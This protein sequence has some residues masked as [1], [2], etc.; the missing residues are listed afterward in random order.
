MS[1]AMP[2]R[3]VLG[4]QQEMDAIPLQHAQ[5]CLDCE[6]ICGWRVMCPQCGGSSLLPLAKV[7]N[8]STEREVRHA[9]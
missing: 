2:C 5:L 9:N 4:Y 3:E 8:R 6:V 7:L 1:L